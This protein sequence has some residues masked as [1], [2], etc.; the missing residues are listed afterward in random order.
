MNMPGHKKN[1]F[2]FINVLC[3]FVYITTYFGRVNLSI[4]LPYL[5]DIYGYSKTSLGLLASGF[6]VAYAAGQLINGIL[7]DKFNPRYLIALGLLLAGLS[8]I[9]FGIVRGIVPLLFFWTMNGYFQS[10]LWGPLVRITT[11]STPSVHLQKAALLLA[12]STIMGY[13]LS[14]TLIGKIVVSFGWEKAFFIPGLILILVTVLWFFGSRSYIR[15]SPSV[16]ERTSSGS[17][18]QGEGPFFFLI[19]TRLWIT[20]LICIFQ[21]SIK[22]GLTLWGPMF[23]SES[24]QIPMDRVLFIMSLVPA[25]NFFGLLAGGIVNHVFRGQEKKT[26]VF[27]LTAALLFAILVRITMGL[28]IIFV[29]ISFAGLFASIFAVNSMLTSFVPLNFKKEERVSAVAGILDSAVYAGAAISG[30]AVGL[31]VDSLGWSGVMNGW[32]A[33][34]VAALIAAAVSRNYKRN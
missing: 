12:S 20:A 34:S 27:F 31:L 2:W 6:F 26:S 18:R 19:R 24:Q 11:E 33:V 32:I 10:M 3:W 22:E 8:N 9:L 4:T 28:N 21:G 16:P 7:G 17:A 30:P 29:M 1:G 25:M 5:Q 15:V 23:F 14:Y 13:L